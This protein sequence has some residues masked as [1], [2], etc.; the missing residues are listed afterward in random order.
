M[1][2]LMISIWQGLRGGTITATLG[3]DPVV[4]GSYVPTYHILGF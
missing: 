1:I 3:G 4:S 2:G